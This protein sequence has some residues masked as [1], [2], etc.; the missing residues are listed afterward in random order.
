MRV[1]I[2]QPH[3]LPWLGYLDKVD[4]AEVFILLDTVQ[5]VKSEWQNRNRILTAQGPQWLTVPVIEHA[6]QRIDTVQIASAPWQKKHA[7][8]L[9]QTY[10]KHPYWE[11]L[12]PAFLALLATRWT[13]LADL[14]MGVLNLLCRTF[15][16]TTPRLRASSFTIL[17][18]NPTERLIDLCRVVGGKTYLSGQAGPG[19]MDLAK[20]DEAGIGV[21]VQAYQHPV[22]RQPREPFVPYLAALDLWSNC[23]PESLTILR[24]GRHYTPAAPRGLEN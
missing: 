22:Y 16:I 1:A 9:K 11:P 18:Q 21:E 6:A 5:Y 7:T 20:L 23:G 13:H 4:A 3:Y 15:G 14:D 12:G 17:R 24:S 8:T 10:G 19:Y 2:H